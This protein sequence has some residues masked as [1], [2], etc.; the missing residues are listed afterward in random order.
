MHVAREHFAQGRYWD[1]TSADSV[2]AT[3]QQLGMDA[4]NLDLPLVD[5]ILLDIM[6]PGIDGFGACSRIK[7]DQRLVDIPIVMVTALTDVDNLRQAFVAGATDCIKE[8]HRPGGIACN[9]L[10]HAH[11]EARNGHEEETRA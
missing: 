10:H 1:T 8:T 9:G 4:V 2:R 7:T 6:M 5:V 3:Y 11:H